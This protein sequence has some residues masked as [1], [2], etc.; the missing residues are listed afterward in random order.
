[1]WSWWS[2]SSLDELTVSPS[3]VEREEPT[4]VVR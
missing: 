2:V 3:Q 4:F 1:M